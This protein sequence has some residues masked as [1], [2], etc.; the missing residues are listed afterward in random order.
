MVVSSNVFNKYKYKLKNSGLD[1]TDLIGPGVTKH[2]EV[3]VTVL[4]FH[5]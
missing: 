1:D 3:L 4:K 2:H 5:G